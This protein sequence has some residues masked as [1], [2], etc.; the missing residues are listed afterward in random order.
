M[1]N[2]GENQSTCRSQISE[3]AYFS[4]LC[5]PYLDIP[6]KD[7]RVHEAKREGSNG[8]GSRNSAEVKYA[9]VLQ[10]SEVIKCIHGMSKNIECHSAQYPNGILA[11]VEIAEFS[12][13][14]EPMLL[15]DGS[16]PE[17]SPFINVL[18]DVT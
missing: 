3:Y 7:I 4:S 11:L 12:W 13:M 2:Y 18:P 15:P 8:H 10:E 17:I 6:V 5:L 16:W 9:L 14:L 1:I